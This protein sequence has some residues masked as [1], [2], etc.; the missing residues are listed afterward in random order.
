MNE[1]FILA[2][3]DY[4]C[5][6]Q[7][8]PLFEHLNPRAWLA[9]FEKTERPFALQLLNAFLYFSAAQTNH[10][11]E[12]AFNTISRSFAS[13]NPSYRTAEQAWNDF[14]SS[15]II[16]PLKGEN[17]NPTD[18][19][20]IF[21]RAARQALGLH[22]EQ[23]V[24][25]HEALASLG[26][27]I[28]PVIFVDDFVGSG[29]Q[30]IKTWERDYSGTSF[31]KLFD[32]GALQTVL[33]C[34]VICTTYGRK[35]IKHS[36]PAIQLFASHFLSEEFSCIDPQSIIAKAIPRNEFHDFIRI[37]SNRAGIPNTKHF[38]FHDLALALAFEHCVPDATL[39]LFYWEQNWA[40]LAKRR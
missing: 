6:V 14:K 25:P 12:G 22:Q 35:R 23:I 34:S 19:G 7:L 8:W 30:C 40:P 38:G 24:E 21:C 16:V 1:E 26:H 33:Y 15:A 2:K 3:C 18:S 29:E 13:N 36:C 17:P 4:F 32:G 20:Y 31:K 5:N 9:N 28:R 39:P 37:A 27:Q 11:F 10:M